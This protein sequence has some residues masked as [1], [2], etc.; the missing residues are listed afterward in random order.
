MNH[1]TR[2]WTSETKNKEQEKQLISQGIQQEAKNEE[3]QTGDTPAITTAEATSSNLPRTGKASLQRVLTF[4]S[5]RG[6]VTT[7]AQLKCGLCGLLARR[8]VRPVCSTSSVCWN[9]AVKEMTRSHQ[10]WEC[11]EAATTELHL[12]QDTQLRQVIKEYLAAE[13]RN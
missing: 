9:C 7:P 12:V 10:C 13:K 8:A 2:I 5:G 1:E 11:E 4:E 3:Y 6:D